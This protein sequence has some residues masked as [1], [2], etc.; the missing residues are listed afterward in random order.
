MGKLTK[1][2]YLVVPREEYARLRALTA[3]NTE[4]VDAV[5]FV[6]WS[7]AKALKAA[8]EKAGLTQAE[9][10]RRLGVTQPMVSG[11]ESGAIHVTERHVGALL[12][13]CKLPRTWTG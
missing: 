11:A 4:V 5:A 7:V 1:A 2:E 9:L 13:A 10:A 8:R 3:V 6:H 12:R